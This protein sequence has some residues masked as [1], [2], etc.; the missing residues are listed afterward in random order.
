MKNKVNLSFLIVLFVFAFLERTVWDLG[1]NFEIVTT[2][3]VISALYLGSR[4]TLLLTFLTIAV[5]D[6]IIGNTN[7]FLF[8]WSGF[9]IPVLLL[10][11]LFKVLK[12]KN[13]STFWNILAVTGS[14]LTANLFF[15]IWT[16]FGVWLLDSVGMY[17]NDVQGLMRSYLNGLPFLKNQF[18]SSII[19]TPLGFY[20]INFITKFNFKSFKNIKL[21]FV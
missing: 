14:G 4:K 19:F 7:I 12:L 8:T 17:S 16:N 20:T 5:S 13:K 1:P 2:A 15:Y 21:R 6:V 11:F 10:P 9:L 3:L 18:L